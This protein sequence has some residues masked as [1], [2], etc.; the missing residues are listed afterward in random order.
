L[1]IIV[2]AAITK[3]NTDTNTVEEHTEPTD[4]SPSL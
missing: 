1:I 4:S 3:K 2:A